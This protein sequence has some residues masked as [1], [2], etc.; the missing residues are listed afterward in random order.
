[1]KFCILSARKVFLQKKIQLRSKAQITCV[2][3]SK[4]T[5]DNDGDTS[6]HRQCIIPSPAG[7]MTH[8]HQDHMGTD[9]FYA[10]NERGSKYFIVVKHTPV[11]SRL[12]MQFN[13]HDIDF[14]TNEW[15]DRGDIT[16]DN[17]NIF[18]NLELM[19]AKYP[20]Y[21][22]QIAQIPVECYLCQQ[23]TFMLY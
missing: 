18:D 15:Q 17:F 16:H 9:V 13:I 3:G 11:T 6:R 19:C 8:G 1:M 10:I 5:V 7:A 20:Q 22:T 14:K 4:W 21:A 12:W 2:F 23:A